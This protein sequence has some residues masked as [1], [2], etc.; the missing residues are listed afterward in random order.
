[1]YPNILIPMNVGHLNDSAGVL[2]RAKRP[3]S[4]GGKMTLTCV[5]G[6]VSG[7]FPEALSD[8][9]LGRRAG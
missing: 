7:F 1:M 4:G 3:F 6:V 5:G 8:E 9:M 2:G